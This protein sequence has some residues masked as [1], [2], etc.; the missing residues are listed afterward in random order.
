MSIA[1]QPSVRPVAQPAAT[2]K[3]WLASNWGLLAA[4]AVLIAILLM[5]TPAGLPIAGHHMLAILAFAVILWM[6]EAARLNA[7][8]AILIAALMAFLL[9]LAP[10][11]ANPKVLLG[12]SG[13]LTLAFS[14]F[15]NTASGACCRRTILGRSDDCDRSRQAHCAQHLV[16]G[17]RNPN[18]P[19]CRRHDPG[20]VRDCA[21]G[22]VHHRARRLPGPDHARHHCGLRRQQARRL[23][24]AC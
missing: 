21:H 22:A 17:V 5:P 8:S 2:E 10:S 16:A 3:G 12:T 6:T 14:G 4:T 19:R 13:A 7:V 23:C 20:R 1:A 24:R 11:V 18:Q 15:A 9:G